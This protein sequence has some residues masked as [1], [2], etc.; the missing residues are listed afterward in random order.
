MSDF[1]NEQQFEANSTSHSDTS[2]MQGFQ[3][4]F[5]VSGFFNSEQR[6]VQQAQ[7]QQEMK[8]QR[9]HDNRKEALAEQAD[10]FLKAQALNSFGKM[11]AK[12]YEPTDEQEET[13]NQVFHAFINEKQFDKIAQLIETGMTLKPEHYA[14]LMLNNKVMYYCL[15][16]ESLDKMKQTEEF[17]ET[18]YA[19]Q[20]ELS[21]QDKEVFFTI[22]QA[23]KSHSQ[24]KNYN[25]RLFKQFMGHIHKIEQFFSHT[26][27]KGSNRFIIGGES[28]PAFCM[29]AGKIQ[30]PSS[31]ISFFDYVVQPLSIK[32]Y[33]ELLEKTNTVKNYTVQT[34]EG[35]SKGNLAVGNEKW[36][37]LINAFHHNLGTYF[38][39]RFSLEIDKILD[40]TESLYMDTYLAKKASE[41]SVKNSQK[42]TLEMLPVSTKNLVQAIRQQYD[43]LSQELIRLDESDKHDL[44]ALV[45]EKLPK[46]IN[47]FLSMKEEYRTTMVNAQGKNAQNLLEESLSNISEHLKNMEVRLNEDNL[48]E[49][50]VGAKYTKAKMN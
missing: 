5:K 33:S 29:L 39:S 24:D 19:N 38:D 3:R 22:G 23:L 1:Q 8:A 47:D 31:S 17:N 9:E 10:Y 6:Q 46:Y 50:S 37:C 15:P 11:L 18:M 25:R 35:K 28:L 43:A 34:E 44:K 36:S 30:I 45:Q 12:G 7:R 41:E 32:E 40:E 49:L 2:L 16:F 13:F 26:N 48:K 4:F 27:E 21:P 42:F 20:Y 14:S